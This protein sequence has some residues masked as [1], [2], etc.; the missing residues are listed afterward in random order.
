MLKDFRLQDPGE[1]IHEVE[2]REILVKPGDRVEDG[3][4][5]FV[6]ESDKAAIEI[7]SPYHGRVAEI[8]VEVGDTIPVGGVLM[9]VDTEGGA[10]ATE[11]PAAARE[12]AAAAAPVAETAAPPPSAPPSPPSRPAVPPPPAA[13]PRKGPLKASPTAR[14]LAKKLGIDLGHVPASGSRGH[15]TR[16]DVE[17]YLAR[18]AAAAATGP[19][20]A[21]P[22]SYEPLPDFSQYGPVRRVPLKS[23]R[24][25]TAR[26]L[27]RAWRE[28]PHAML[29]DK[30]DMTELERFRRRHAIRVAAEGG[31]L[32]RTVLIVK[33]A[34][35]ALRKHPRFNASIDMNAGEI[36]EKD[37]INV[38]IAVDTKL[39]LIVP[40]IRN[41]D[42]LSLFDLSV[43]IRDV[44]ERAREGKVTPEDL[45]GG[46]F[47]ITNIG[48]LGSTGFIPIINHPEVAILG[49][50]RGRIEPVIVGDLDH[51]HVE[52]RYMVPFS[53]AFDHRV[54]DGADAAR[55][56]GTF[57]KILADPENFAIH[58]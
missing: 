57:R 39:G 52:A 36:I 4:P 30:I 50:G 13:T 53:I 16:A 5:A 35:I 28:I 43:A 41:A 23:V 26:H 45:S 40:V 48:I 22:V 51:Y 32:T 18:P 55:F 20:A 44:A 54:N 8:T 47:T 10:P 17:A 25:A 33:A 49:C 27:A 9:R 37:Y 14:K 31:R 2:I 6:V 58:S 11:E 7:T 1:G 21:G 3:D 56:L 19:V 34:L 15:I 38:G 46:T 12:M 42:R 24:K 29:E